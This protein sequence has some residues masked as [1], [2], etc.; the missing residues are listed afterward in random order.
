MKIKIISWNVRG[1]N[2]AEKRRLE[3]CNILTELWAHRWVGE[4][5][6]EAK[7]SR[8]GIMI[9]WNKR[10]WVGEMV[11]ST[12]QMISC[13]VTGV[14]QDIAWLL[15]AVYASCNRVIRRELWSELEA[16]RNNWEGPWRVC[17]DFN[18]TR[19]VGE[20]VNR[21]RLSRAMFELS[22]AINNL[23]L[24]D[25]PLL[26]R[27]YTWR[28]RENH[29]S[30]S[31]IDRFLYSV[32][33]EDSLQLV[34]QSLLPRI[35]SD[36]NPILLTYGDWN[37]KK[38]YFKFENWWLEVEGFKQ[39]VKAWWLSFPNMGKPAFNLANKLKLLKKELM[40]WSRSNEGDWKHKKE[41]I[42]QQLKSREAIQENRSLTDDEL[43]QKTHLA[44]EF[45][46]IAKEEEIAWR[47]RSR[48]QWLKNGDK[49]TRFFYRMANAHKRYN[50]IDALEVEG[51]S[52][53]EMSAVKNAIQRFYQNLY[54]ETEGRRPDLKLQGITTLASILGCGVGSLPIV[55]LGMPLDRKHGDLEIWDTIL[56][57]AEKRLAKWKARSLH[58]RGPDPQSY[59]DGMDNA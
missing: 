35:G 4:V 55:Y 58:N 27:S 46:E 31:K 6:L 30:A 10:E 17:G 48:I 45:E 51:Q 14:C 49:N 56:E 59:K 44:M 9:M 47:Q 23:E 36:H 25:P 7:G 34:K 16:S 33:W 3:R 40:R 15:S 52:I 57:K 43:V 19:F 41:M 42:L 37:Y 20:R 39:K 53:N 21:H 13:T 28:R 11:D 38:T 29:N 1:L 22:E 50:S 54:K 2:G 26:G 5:Q 12:G 32:D 24:V 18:V 8:G